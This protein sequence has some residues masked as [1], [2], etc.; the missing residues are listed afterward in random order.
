MTPAT[1]LGVFGHPSQH[2]DFDDFLDIHA[3]DRHNCCADQEGKMR[4]RVNVTAL[5]NFGH[6][7]FSKTFQK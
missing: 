1:I 2:S 5:L 7:R 3:G 4:L 6:V